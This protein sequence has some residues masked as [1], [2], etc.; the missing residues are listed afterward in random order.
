M[1]SGTTGSSDDRL[2]RISLQ[3]EHSRQTRNTPKAKLDRAPSA[4]LGWRR[5][6]LNIVPLCEVNWGLK[7]GTAALFIYLLIYLIICLPLRCAIVCSTSCVHEGKMSLQSFLS[8]G[9]E[10]F[11]KWSEQSIVSSCSLLGRH[12]KCARQVGLCYKGCTGEV[13]IF[14]EF[15]VFAKYGT[16]QHSLISLSQSTVCLYCFNVKQNT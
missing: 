11:S 10:M 5:R 2:Q 7:E 13:L 9:E 8:T 14:P 15:N 3:P 1:S 6:P 12:I 16:L 4:A